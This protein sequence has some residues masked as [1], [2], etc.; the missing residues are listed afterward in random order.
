MANARQIMSLRHVEVFN[1]VYQ[2]GSVSGAARALN[3][4][5]PSVSK[6]LRHAESR[7]GFVLF[8]IVKG[9]LVPTDEA[10]I[11]F[12]EARELYARVESLQE[13][14]KNL[15][16][17]AGGSLR[18]AVLP[19]L[20]L[21]IA[22][23]AVARFH[24]DNPTVAFEIQTLHNGDVLR[25]LYE[26]NSDLALAHDAPHHPR[27]VSS[28]VGSGELVL[29]FRKTDLP[30]PPDLVPLD[31][32]K[33]HNLIRLSGTGAIGTLFTNNIAGGQGAPASIAVQTYYIAASLA[34][35]G[36]GIAVVDE[37]TARASLSP[38]MDFRRLEHRPA[39]DIHCVHLEDRPLSGS[40]KKFM[41]VLQA[42]IKTA[43]QANG[44]EA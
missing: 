11:L 35:R 31:M 16:L 15:R 2:T 13:T 26:R 34:R 21:E 38:D 32:L 12:Q 39:F 20:G 9:R 14:A 36:A 29:L 4:S 1:A 25:S 43:R 19:S 8:R 3:V 37:F 7:I 6:V 41:S 24:A 30:D 33:R 10:H 5:Q 44:A 17:G 22:P 28:K 40:A 23:D 18:L 27:L 42:T